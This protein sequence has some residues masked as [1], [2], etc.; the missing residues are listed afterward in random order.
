MESCG[1]GKGGTAAAVPAA[2]TLSAK[3]PRRSQVFES[4]AH[5]ILHT[6]VF[7]AITNLRDYTPTPTRGCSFGGWPVA[8]P[9]AS[10]VPAEMRRWQPQGAV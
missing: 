3:R 2:K 5:C 10:E 8:V 9:M 6:L 7:V 4:T 1:L